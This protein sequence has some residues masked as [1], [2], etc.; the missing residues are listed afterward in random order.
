MTPYNDINAL[1]LVYRSEA[2]EYYEQPATDL[3]IAGTLI[4]P[5]TGDDMDLVGWRTRGE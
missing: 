1:V 5:E 4:D 2:G 3:I